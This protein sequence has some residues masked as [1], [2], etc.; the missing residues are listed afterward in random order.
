MS[1]AIQFFLKIHFPRD[2][3]HSTLTL[4]AWHVTICSKEPDP[5]DSIGTR[6]HSCYCLYLPLFIHLAPTEQ[7][8]L[9]HDKYRWKKP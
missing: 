2:I 5:E 7:P 4:W 3:N 8:A 1:F 9:G 6:S